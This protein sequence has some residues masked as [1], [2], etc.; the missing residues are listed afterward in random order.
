MPQRM[1]DRVQ[2]VPKWL[3]ISSTVLHVL[4]QWEDPHV[5]LCVSLEPVL[6][7]VLHGDLLG[8]G[9]PNIVSFRGFR[10][11]RTCGFAICMICYRE[12]PKKESTKCNVSSS[13][14]GLA[15]ERCSVS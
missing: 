2:L 10:V 11:L 7:G 12:R 13:L 3:R 4:P 14:E 6:E 9:L 1:C 8:G 15:R 5:F